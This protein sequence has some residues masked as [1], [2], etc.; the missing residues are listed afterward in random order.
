MQRLPGSGPGGLSAGQ[1]GRD[2]IGLAERALTAVP[3]LNG[4]TVST[5][6]EPAAATP[7]PP[8]PTTPV[9]V[10]EAVMPE[11]ATPKP[12][13]P[14]PVEPAAVSPIVAPEPVAPDTAE[15][16]GT[17]TAAAPAGVPAQVDEP[18]AESETVAETTATDAGGEAGGAS[19]AMG[20]AIPPSGEVVEAP[21]PDTPAP[22]DATTGDQAAS[23]REAEAPEPEPEPSPAEATAPVTAAVSR[24][25]RASSAHQPAPAAASNAVASGN[26]PDVTQ[27]RAA[28][29]Q[30]VAGADGATTSEV[31]QDSFERALR[32]AI[33]N[34]MPKP[35]NESEAKDVMNH[36]AE[37]ANRALGETMG[38]QQ[39]Q[40]VGNLPEA[41]DETQQPNP[42]DMPGGDVVEISSD[43][44]GQ[45]P[46]AVSAAPVVAP[47]STEAAIDTSEN[48]ERVDALEAENNVTRDQLTK[49]QDPQFE[50]A[51]GARE[52][53]ETNDREAPQRLR[54]AEAVD[55]AGTR[56]RAAGA[57]AGG[58][59]D[60]H[61]ERVGRLANVAGQQSATKGLTEERKRQITADI[62]AIGKATR[63][64]VTQILNDM[65]AKVNKTFGDALDQAMKLYDAEFEDVKGGFGTWV[66]DVFSGT[67]SEER[68]EMAF[69]AGR[70]VYD[71]HIS[72]AITEVAG[73]VEDHLQRARDRVA[74]GRA[75]IDRY[76]SEEVSEAEADYAEQATATITADFDSLEGEIDGRRDAL[77]NRMV[78][79][80]REGIER[81]NAREEQLREE[82]KSFW[83]RVYDATVG[84]I[85]KVLEF[86]NMLLG[87][88][89]RAA[90][91]VEAII[92][93]PIGFLKNL[94]AGIGAG[95]ERFVSNIGENLKKA[96]M[97]WL[98]GALEGAGIQLPDTFDF[99]GVLS[100]ILQVLGLTKENIRAR[101]VRILGEETVLK[102]EAAVD[103]LRI[104]FTEG[105][106]GIWQML[107][108][109]L[110]MLKDA[111]LDEIK[112]W[113]ITQVI[114][115]GIKWIVSLL[116]PASAFVKACLMIYDIVVFFIERGRQI[117]S[118]VN[119][120]IDS[121]AIIVAGNI[122]AM[123]KA[124][125]EALN[126]ILP[127]VIS[128]LAALLGLGGISDTIRGIIEKI[129]EPVNKVIDWVINMGLGIAQKIA[130]FF[131]GKNENDRV[132]EEERD[133]STDAE[134]SVTDSITMDG[135][136]HTLIAE[137]RGGQ[138]FVGMASARFDSLETLIY[139]A[140]RQEQ[141][142]QNRGEVVAKLDEVLDKI[143]DLR[144][145]WAA[146]AYSEEGEAKAKEKV[147]SW[148]N[149]IGAFL[150]GFGDDY[151]IPDLKNLGHPSRFVEGDRLKDEYHGQERKLFYPSRYWADVEQWKRDELAKYP[152]NKF[153]DA[154]TG[155]MEPKSKATVDHKPMVWEHWSNKGG[156]DMK[157]SQRATYYND[158]ANLSLS[159]HANNSSDGALARAM[160][161]SYVKTVGPHFRGPGEED[162]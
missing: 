117:I 137:V 81:R 88:L 18:E 49:G 41:V 27:R 20:G 53:A 15:P 118:V 55:R 136:G 130:G 26:Q 119:A 131:G 133:T 142:G 38:Q 35:R 66:S 159:T 7:K 153:K 128:F 11:A 17:S 97:G 43:E 36:G 23:D 135:H 109:K 63:D 151:D 162:L 54:E 115:A 122:G 89:A 42:G 14:E 47:P 56:D 104:L 80:Y 30:G 5:R 158:L 155:K 126:R 160:G 86:K 12:V 67:S 124:V 44:P 87:I 50:T 93:D 69:Q 51:L 76:M 79:M 144:E 95:L 161:A 25:A 123:A 138:M 107:L 10:P 152:G 28:Q 71:E 3:S 82:N 99:K 106:A 2:S 74:E 113:V 1:V 39:T 114:T 139:G 101:A 125:E 105:P 9:A 31:D 52:E 102:I 45:P 29:Q 8:A 61:G 34:A 32:T 92:Q 149:G 60:F 78:G 68:L 121:L 148:L 98:F 83:Q 134:V 108:E 59:N 65:D 64:G 75:E 145:D 19:G 154:L 103:F 129:Q 4:E 37:R 147:L 96:L 77:V 156:N 21:V 16:S 48:R 70:S 120:I 157:Q 85:Q 58:L 40:A 62:E 46:A 73:I 6:P 91:V 84:V 22:T 72:G 146:A 127:V 94:I 100:I 141:K 132:T 116:N 90:G 57:L 140:R 150:Q 24:R 110:G 33:E 13:T 112:S 111:I 143:K